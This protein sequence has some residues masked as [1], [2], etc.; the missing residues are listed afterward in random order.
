MK[1][2]CIVT[3]PS[4]DTQMLLA[5]QGLYMMGFT[6]K[7]I[8][9][10]L[11]FPEKTI[12]YT[13]RKEDWK[14]HSDLIDRLESLDRVSNSYLREM[15]ELKSQYSSDKNQVDRLSGVVNGLN[16]RNIELLAEVSSLKGSLDKQKKAYFKVSGKL[17]EYH[18]CSWFKL[19]KIAFMRFIGLED[20]TVF[21]LEEVSSKDIKS[22][23]ESMIKG[24]HSGEQ[25]RKASINSQ[26]AFNDLAKA[27]GKLEVKVKNNF[28]SK[29]VDK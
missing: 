8:S 26:N 28:G 20:K 15:S 7:Q 10:Y 24:S 18:N 11:D 3:K 9:R 2:K 27:M 14:R 5:C 12:R 4:E 23:T 13:R 29:R 19:L 16:R 17:S 22:M 6:Y 25:L 21:K 1:S